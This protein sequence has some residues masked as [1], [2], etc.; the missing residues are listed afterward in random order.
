MPS[1]GYAT[2]AGWGSL[3]TISWSEYPPLWSDDTP[4]VEN[5]SFAMSMG[6]ASANN[7]KYIEGV[8]F[9]Q[10]LGLLS[11]STQTFVIDESPFH[12]VL[13]LESK[14]TLLW[15][16]VEDA[17]TEWTPIDYPN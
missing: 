17:N 1:Q 10:T 12:M 13:G 5:V 2:E 7:F 15:S 8:T 14:P 6:M 16:K 11:N 9:D 4:L 3:G